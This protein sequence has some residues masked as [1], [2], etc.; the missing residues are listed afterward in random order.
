[1]TELTQLMLQLIQLKE[2]TIQFIDTMNNFLY[3]NIPI[4]LFIYSVSISLGIIFGI[5][6]YNLIIS[7]PVHVYILNHNFMPIP[8]ITL[9]HKLTPHPIF[10]NA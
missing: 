2:E 8:T 4:L 5:Y 9:E 1:M 3:L 6:L 7:Q 10:P